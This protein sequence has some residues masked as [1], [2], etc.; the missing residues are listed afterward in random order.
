MKIT[1]KILF[2]L[3]AMGLIDIF[4]PLPIAVFLLIYVLQS[5]P[6]WFRD[7]VDEVYNRG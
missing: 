4:I 2:F 7:M 1:T 5:K 3:I 6:V